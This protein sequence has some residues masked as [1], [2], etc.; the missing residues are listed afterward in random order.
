MTSEMIAPVPEVTTTGHG[1]VLDGETIDKKCA[2]S[3]F[4][5]AVVGFFLSTVVVT[6]L[7]LVAFDIEVASAVA[8]GLFVGVWG[9]LGF[10]MM[11]GG[12]NALA[13]ALGEK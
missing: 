4:I 7:L 9:G 2:R 8:L 5:G 6:V 3:A 13:D 10:G 1:P 11:V 12:V